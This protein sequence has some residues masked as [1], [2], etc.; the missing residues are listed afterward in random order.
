MTRSSCLCACL[1]ALLSSAA[2]IPEYDAAPDRQTRGR[3][4]RFHWYRQGIEHGN[5]GQE[6]R[7][8]INAPEASLHPTFGR[9]P[10][11]RENGMMLIKAEEDLSR[12]LAA[13][14]YAELWGGHPGTA[15]KRVTINGRSTYALPP[16]GTEEG[17]CTYSYPA[18]PL[19]LTDLVCG[20]NA[21]QFALDQGT[22]FW[23]HALID[24]A[25]VRA[26]LPDTHPDLAKLGLNRFTASVVAVPASEGAGYELRLECDAGAVPLI[27]CVEYAGWYRGYDENGNRL[28]E[29]WHG[30]TKH[31]AAHAHLGTAVAAPF[32]LRWD[33]SMLPAQTDAAVRAIVRFAA[34][35]ELVFATI[36]ARNL[37]IT[38]PDGVQVLIAAP[39][40]LP[41]RFWSR[42]GQRKSCSFELDIDP[43][44]VTRAELHCVAW[45]GGA[46]AVEE[47]FTLNG[48]LFPIAEGSR[49]EV[50]YSRLAVDP[51]LLRRGRNPVDLLSDTEH[52]GIEIL[53]PGPALIIRCR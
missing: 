28:G 36:P 25:A 12:L 32:R 50:E 9:R 48:M 34:D 15:N 20:F 11:A 3:F 31:R 10:E 8:R 35:P 13:E 40:D 26:A 38:H 1:A 17:H 18:V 22:A 23:G 46:G 6:M 42:A 29:D 27:A 47:Y 37:A 49:H 7:F 53:L 52:H 43:A 24:N 2:A 30:F 41:D 45:T 4:W 33:A 14:L 39:R 44:R 21:L 5:P 51:R 19:K 16:V